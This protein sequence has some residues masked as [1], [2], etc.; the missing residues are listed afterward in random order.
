LIWQEPQL[1]E[2]AAQASLDELLDEAL[3]AGLDESS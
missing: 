1:E 3:Q 2:F